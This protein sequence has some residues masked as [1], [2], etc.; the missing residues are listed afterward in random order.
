[1]DIISYIH[2]SVALLFQIF[3]L[4]EVWTHRNMELSPGWYEAHS[5]HAKKL[6]VRPFL[7]LN[8]IGAPLQEEQKSIFSGLKINEMAL[9]GQ[10]D[11]KTIFPSA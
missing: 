6:E 1:M 2:K 7:F 10:I 11:F 5:I 3:E 8:F 9:S 4:V